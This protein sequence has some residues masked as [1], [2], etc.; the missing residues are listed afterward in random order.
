MKRHKE[1]EMNRINCCITLKPNKGLVICI[2][3]NHSETLASSLKLNFSYSFPGVIWKMVALPAEKL[4]LLEIRDETN[5]QVSFSALDYPRKTFLWKDFQLDESWWTGLLAAYK[6]VFLV[7]NYTS[8]ENPD[9][10]ALIAMDIHSCNILWEQQNFS[11]SNLSN[12]NVLGMLGR[13]DPKLVGLDLFTGRMI[14]GDVEL[15]LGANEIS[16]PIR[17]FQ[18]QEGTSYYDTVYNFLTSSCSI[19]PEGTV[20][21]QEYDGLILISYYIREENGLA[22]YLLVLNDTGDVLLQEKI[23]EQLKGL[24]V[25]TFF[26]LSGC[27]FFVRNKRELLSYL[28]L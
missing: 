26:I 21:Y 5:R 19:K 23:D 11:F 14:E 2:K 17:P 18:Y 27:L 12:G 13:E 7:Q 16:E 9:V 22:N 1:R 25:D 4:L 24:G 10:T 6:S 3:L 20:E 8:Q 28:I 15:E